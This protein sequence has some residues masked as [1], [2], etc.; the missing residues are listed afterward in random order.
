MHWAHKALS[1]HLCVSPMDGIIAPGNRIVKHSVV[2]G[3]F[4]VF[5]AWAHPS[6]QVDPGLIG[7]QH[8]RLAIGVVAKD[9]FPPVQIEAVRRFILPVLVTK[10]ADDQYFLPV[11]LHGILVEP[12]G[13]LAE[14]PVFAPAD[15]GQALAQA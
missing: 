1:P 7:P 15:A 3:R 4:F 11:V 6:P 2:T 14:L 5:P 12:F 8:I 10:R 13:A 9:Q